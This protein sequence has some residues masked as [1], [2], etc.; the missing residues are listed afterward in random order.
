[1]CLGQRE[2]YPFAIVIAMRTFGS[3]YLLLRLSLWSNCWNLSV[4]V[5][6]TIFVLCSFHISFQLFFFLFSLFILILAFSSFSSLSLSI[7][8]SLSI[9]LRR[10]EFL[11]KFFCKAH[12]AAPGWVWGYWSSGW[13]PNPVVVPPDDSIFALYL[14]G[15]LLMTPMEYLVLHLIMLVPVAAFE[16][17]E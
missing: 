4:Q 15:F 16:P 9:F 13:N 7:P 6:P 10:S 1:M 5:L 17:G 12:F 14:F 3:L 8:P 2:D 11:Q